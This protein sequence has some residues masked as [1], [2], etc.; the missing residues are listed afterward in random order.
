[1]VLHV[2]FFGEKRVEKIN[3]KAKPVKFCSA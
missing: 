1:L 2:Y 3:H